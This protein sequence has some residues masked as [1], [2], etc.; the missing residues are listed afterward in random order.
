MR[1]NN[2]VFLVIF[3]TCSV[4]SNWYISLLPPIVLDNPFALNSWVYCE[5]RT[6][7]IKSPQRTVYY[8]Y[9]VHNNIPIRH[10]DNVIQIQEISRN[11]PRKILP[12]AILLYIYILRNKH[13]NRDY[14]CQ[15]EITTVKQ[16][17]QLSNRY[18]NVKKN[19]QTWLDKKN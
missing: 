16:R 8:M 13:K 5:I 14:N 12:P 3:D 2:F 7:Q 19:P 4:V 11:L 6:N 9:I 17:L 1:E 10:V 18:Y 15:T